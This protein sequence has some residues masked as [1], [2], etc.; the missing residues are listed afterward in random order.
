MSKL[1]RRFE[2]RAPGRLGGLLAL[3]ILVGAACAEPTGPPHAD[4]PAGEPQQAGLSSTGEWIGGSWSVH[5][6]ESGEPVVLLHRDGNA[7]LLD[8]YEKTIVARYGERAV[9]RF[10]YA[11]SSG[12]DDDD[13]DVR[14]G[15]TFLKFEVGSLSLS[16]H[17]DGSP[18]LPGDEVLITVSID[19]D[20]LVAQF[21]PAG[22]S[23]SP[24]HPARLRMHYQWADSDTDDDGVE[25]LDESGIRVVGQ[26]QP[27]DPWFHV[28][29]TPEESKDRIEAR[30][31]GFTRYSLGI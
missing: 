19:P 21:E 5:N 14:W 24:T 7:P 13:D 26:E 23:F 29:Q 9:V 2:W 22:L 10:R 15:K 12:D 17:P 3:I 25:D 18:V 20:L 4:V 31:T 27:G 6:S 1:G 28:D 16:H 11:A 30:L 8:S